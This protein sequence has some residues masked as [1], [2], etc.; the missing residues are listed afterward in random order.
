ME[1]KEII[2]SRR[3]EL[4]LS[5]HDVVKYVGVSE[6]T[7]SRWESGDIANIGRSRILALAKILEL[8]PL[9]ILG[10]EQKTPPAEA[11]GEITF[12]DFTYALLNE[13]D[14]LDDE[15]KDTLL[16]MAKHMAERKKKKG[17]E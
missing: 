13:S 5:Q 10:E 6:A 14:Q 2:K 7:V 15:D 9:V 17:G 12:D 11:E 1:V 4:G 3:I 16:A 8:S